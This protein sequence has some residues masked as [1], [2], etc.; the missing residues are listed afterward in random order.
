MI[1]RAPIGLLAIL[2]SCHA[3]A[4]ELDTPKFHIVVT[5]NCPEGDVA[6]AD[7]TYIGTSKATGASVKLKGK[8]LVH[9]CADG[10]TPCHHLGYRFRRGSYDYFVGEN[11]NLVVTHHGKVIVD[12][13][14]SWS[15]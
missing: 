1:N 13:M 4:G 9:W 6:C 12:E 8:T 10:T 2:L 11:G 5:E 7:V 3:L 15:Y 14:G